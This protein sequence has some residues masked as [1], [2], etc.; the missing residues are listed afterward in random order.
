MRS[1]LCNTMAQVARSMWS[2]EFQKG[3]KAPQF[4]LPPTGRI[5]IAGMPDF[6]RDVN[7]KQAKDEIHP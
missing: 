6:W 1:S 7:D 3:T 4:W 2:E 5:R